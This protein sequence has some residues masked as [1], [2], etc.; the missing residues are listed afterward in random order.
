[1]YSGGVPHYNFWL[2]RQETSKNGSKSGRRPKALFIIT[3]FCFFSDLT[4]LML[5][6]ECWESVQIILVLY[7]SKVEHTIY[8]VVHYLWHYYY[9]KWVICGQMST[10][11]KTG[12]FGKYYQLNQIEERTCS[13]FLGGNWL[14][15]LLIALHRNYH[16]KKAQSSSHSACLRDR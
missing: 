1:M 10:S 14:W 3:A 4:L 8:H 6:E 9:Y 12:I 5:S 2:A 11:G 13:T 7:L 15:T 16:Y